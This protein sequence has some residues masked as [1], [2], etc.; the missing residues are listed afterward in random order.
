MAVGL[1]R[2]FQ[3]LPS[4]VAGGRVV[5]AAT[6]LEDGRKE[7]DQA[8]CDALGGLCAKFCAGT[9]GQVRPLGSWRSS[10]HRG[11]HAPPH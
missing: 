1:Q 9:Q 5:P 3:I 4:R 11:H 7:K 6:K 10:P 8:L 2:H